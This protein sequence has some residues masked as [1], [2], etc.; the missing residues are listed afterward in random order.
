MSRVTV[1]P[2][3]A[4]VR[5][6]KT[7]MPIYSSH[8]DLLRGSAALVVLF[9]HL[10]F[11]LEDLARKPQGKVPWDVGWAA[12]A[13]KN[14]VNMMN[15]P[16]EAVIV[17]FVLSG[18]LVGGSVLRNHK[19]NQF[20]W[21]SYTFKRLRRLLTVLI[22]AL[23]FGALVDLSSRSILDHARANALG[24]L[25][26]IQFHL[27]F[28]TFLGN[29][30]FLQILDRTRLPSF[31]SNTALWSLSAEF[32]YY[33]LFPLLV[34]AIFAKAARPRLGFLALSVVVAV[35]LWK[36]PLSHFPIWAL[37]SLVTLLPLVIKAK[38]Q[39]IAVALGFLQFAAAGLFLWKRPFPSRFLD[40]SLLSI[41][42]ALLLYCILHQRQVR[43]KTV[44]A[45]VAESLAAMSFTLYLFHLPLV[46]LFVILLASYSPGLASHHGLATLFIGPGTYLVCYL[47]YLLFERNT[48]RIT[49]FNTGSSVRIGTTRN[50]A[51]VHT[52]SAPMDT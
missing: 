11:T 52:A 29:L 46:T 40:D 38:Y 36:N 44:Y 33:L 47:F 16:H 23:V 37:G 10:R 19:S 20:S 18:T 30:L 51:A 25:E 9:G 35:F 13:G 48:D 49:F 1:N 4:S 3:P 42:C 45:H 31:G 2:L 14:P 21:G 41:S 12:A 26:D 8:L 5:Q 43:V 34:A 50:K 15:P 28:K 6:A 39:R 22:P 27:E 17:F 7:Q 32:W 24:R